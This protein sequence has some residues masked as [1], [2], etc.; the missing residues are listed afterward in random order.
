MKDDTSAGTK[1][2]RAKAAK[3]EKARAVAQAKLREAVAKIAAERTTE[4]GKACV[5]AAERLIDMGEL[6]EARHWV[7]LSLTADK[8]K[9]DVKL[10]KALEKLEKKGENEDRFEAARRGSKKKGE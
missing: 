9:A 5:A 2:E 6:V 7:S 1:A 8:A 4:S 3:V 10:H